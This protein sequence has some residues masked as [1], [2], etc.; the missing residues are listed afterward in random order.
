MRTFFLEDKIFFE[1]SLPLKSTKKWPK[2]YHQIATRP[3]TSLQQ[4][5][6][7]LLFPYSFSGEG[8]YLVF[9]FSPLVMASELELFKSETSWM[10]RATWKKL[11]IFPWTL[12][13]WI[14]VTILRRQFSMFMLMFLFPFLFTFWFFAFLS[15]PSFFTVTCILAAFLWIALACCRFFK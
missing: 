5:T 6:A 11:S 15:L 1:H 7:E 2:F 8:P 10:T 3:E 12:C 9:V 4:I 13:F 14:T